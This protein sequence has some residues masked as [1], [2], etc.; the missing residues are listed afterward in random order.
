MGASK[1]P[2][3]ITPGQAAQA[4]VGTAGAG[5]MMSIANQPVDQYGNLLNTEA[6]GPA[7]IQ[8][9]QALMNQ[10][11]YQGAVAQRD[12]QSRV[13]PQAYAQREMR[14]QQA[15]KRLGKLYNV[16]PS[17]YNYRGNSA[18]TIPGTADQP[19]LADL[20]ANAAAVASMLSTAS[21]NNAGADPRLNKPV[22]PTAIPVPTATN[23]YLS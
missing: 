12:I 7:Q 19:N 21:V 3:P 16:D 6:L 23:T 8:T 22:G 14:M 5:E 20:K 10:A 4:A 11:A 9:Q 13:D 2:D 1:T 17:S 18:Y 15:N